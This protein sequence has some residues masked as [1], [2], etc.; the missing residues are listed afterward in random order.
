[1]KRKK[2]FGKSYGVYLSVN[3]QKAL[4]KETRRQL[5]EITRK[6]E[7]DIDALVLWHLHEEF[8]WGPK[9][10][11]RFFDTFSVAIKELSDWYAMEETD[12]AWLEAYKLK[13]Y[14]ID[15]EKWSKE[16]DK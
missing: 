11:R 3:E 13:E 9:R 2:A 4:D 16:N 10:L 12:Q 14:G 15:I 8:G 6:H 1:M 7:L 5:A